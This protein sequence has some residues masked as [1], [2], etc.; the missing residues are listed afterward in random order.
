MTSPLA[1]RTGPPIG[2]DSAIPE[3]ITVAQGMGTC[4]SPGQ[5]RGVLGL[6][7]P[8]NHGEGGLGEIVPQRKWGPR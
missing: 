6:A 2:L 8:Q 7:A 3:P 5:E 1:L 4:L